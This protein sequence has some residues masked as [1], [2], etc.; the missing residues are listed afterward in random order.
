M[1]IKMNI[2]KKILL[3]FLILLP[4]NL[5]AGPGPVPIQHEVHITTTDRADEEVYAYY[6]LRN[7]SS[8]VQVTYE[9]DERNP[10]CIHVQI[11]QQDKGCSELDFEDQLTPNDTVVYDMDNII[12]NK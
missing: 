2:F 1:G 9:D 7:R 4:F 10:I 12:R 3:S 6:D 11:F 5:F 8:Y